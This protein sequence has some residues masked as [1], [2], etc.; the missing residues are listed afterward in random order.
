MVFFLPKLYDVLKSDVKQ[1]KIVDK[2][3]FISSRAIINSTKLSENDKIIKI[4]ELNN[5]DKMIICSD[6]NYLNFKISEI[7][8]LKKTSV[9]IVSIKID[10]KEKNN[11]KCS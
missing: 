3:E 10:E 2:K 4:I 5:E 11:S 1:D 8:E 7:S 6:K 9:G